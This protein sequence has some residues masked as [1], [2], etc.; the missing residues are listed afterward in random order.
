M[1]STLKRKHEY[2]Q[3]VK[4]LYLRR[5]FAAHLSHFKEKSVCYVGVWIRQTYT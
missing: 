4:N 3:S 2:P 5:V 1:L